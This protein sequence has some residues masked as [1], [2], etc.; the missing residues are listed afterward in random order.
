MLRT[1]FKISFR[2]LLKHKGLSITNVLGLTLG[3]AAFMLIGLFIKYEL[4]WDKINNNYDRIYRIQRHYSKTMFAM[5]GNDISPHSRAITAQLLEKQFPEFEKV[6]VIR[7]N[8]G[9][10]L[11][12]DNE[13]QV[14]DEKGIHADSCFF[15]IFSYR[16]IEGN[17]TSAID[18]P[19]TIV[20]SKTMADK[21]FG[22]A[23][24]I[25]KTVILDKKHQLR[26]TGVYQELPYNSS[27]RPSY[28]I[29]FG[30]LASINGITRHDMWSGDCMTYA[31]VKP[32]VDVKSLENKIKHIFLGIQGVEYEELQLCPLSKIYLNFNGQNDY[33]IVLYLFGLIGV[34]ILLMSVFNYINLTIAKA[35]VRGKEV[36]VKKVIGSNRWSLIVQFLCET[37]VVAFVSLVLAFLL[38][39]AFL[40]V[41]SNIV[42]KQ[43]DMNL[44]D[45]WKF[46]SVMVLVAF[47]VG[48]L[49][50][51]YPALFLSSHKIISLFKGELFGKDLETF[52]LKKALVTFQFAISVFLILLSMSFSLQVKH[53]AHKDLRFEKDGLLY[54]RLTVS[55]KGTMF[56]QLRDRILQHPEIKNASMSKNLPFVSFGGGMTNWE[57]GDPNDKIS[58]RFNEVSY[59]YFST[60]KAKLVAGRDFSRD[61]PGDVGKA[62]IINETAVKCFGWDEPIGK[63]LN[64]NR[65][66][67]VGVVQNFVYKD[68]HNGIEPAI[69]VLAPQ[70]TLGD[71]IFAFRVDEK[72]QTN[73]KAILTEE[74]EKAFPNDPFE[75]RDVP[76]A[77]NNE[78]SFKIYHS[79][80]RSIFFFTILNIFLAIIGLLGLVSFTVVRRTKEIGVRKI[81]G[82][83]SMNIFYL[84]SREYYI[85]LFWALVIAIPAAWWAYMMLPSANKM[86]AQ[87]WVFVLGASILFIIILLSTSYQ[88]LKAAT[89]NPVEALRYE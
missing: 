69:M 2:N 80:N 48:V 8:G 51:I 32:N 19:F 82:S 60:L 24:A 83:S 49:S 12:A 72:D 77:F 67:V 25:G 71:W 84:L 39:K 88:T 21:L 29:S 55:Q 6:S 1:L 34:F 30:T 33:L 66:K 15:D 37:I 17:I 7:E 35:S 53:I 76:S 31:L 62:C 70:E 75:F 13:H 36:A 64:D 87:P 28:I 43:L 58:C 14:Y 9:M 3:F 61:F 41:F 10:F 79:V 81:N 47:M 57:G 42:D 86:P 44:I 45:N 63:R 54:A 59:D 65:L 26:V 50:G 78:N 27:V 23:S 18:E 89:R 40:P 56:D 4:N 16:F 52:S 74:F 22:N 85:L 38:T 20:L 68:M 11:S 46:L 5:D 73:A